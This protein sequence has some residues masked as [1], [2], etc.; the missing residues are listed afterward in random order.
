MPRELTYNARV[1]K[2]S[3]LVIALG[4]TA[5]ISCRSG[6]GHYVAAEVPEAELLKLVPAALSYAPQPVAEEQNRW[7]ALLTALEPRPSITAE[8]RIALDLV[9]SSPALGA[10]PKVARDLDSMI[11]KFEGSFA[12]ARKALSRPESSIGFLK[13]GELPMKTM[14]PIRQLVSLAAKKGTFEL[15]RGKV[16]AAIDDFELALNLGLTVAEAEAPFEYAVMAGSLISRAYREIRDAAW[17]PKMTASGVERLIRILPESESLH[18]SFKAS[19]KSDFYWFIRNEVMRLKGPGANSRADQDKSMSSR[20]YDSGWQQADDMAQTLLKDH[21]EPY[22]R[23][24]TVI[25]AAALY[26]EML[27]NIDRRWDQQ[28]MIG[29][30]LG[31]LVAEWPVLVLS[32]ADSSHPAVKA[33]VEKSRPGLL[34]AVNPYGRFAVWYFIQLSRQ[35]VL[36]PFRNRSDLEATRLTLHLR[37]FEMENGRLP[38]QLTELG[39]MSGL[40]KLPDDPFTGTPF[41][42]D[43]GRKRLWSAGQNGK[44]D[45]GRE[46]PTL[47]ATA[48]DYVYAL[49]RVMPSPTTLPPMPGAFSTPQTKG[50][51]PIA[52]APPMPQNR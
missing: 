30:T 38:A 11:A 39:G 19:V 14:G 44:D 40:A 28:T 29:E 33:E 13:G 18:R 7:T 48:R 16:E 35:S 5:G 25:R 8:E 37:K 9:T 21:P 2:G 6:P 36:I 10:D 24:D 26:Q 46:A 27:D 52:G 20:D 17:H 32:G 31:G 22:D 50:R 23:K 42:Y 1:R 51:A 47:S 45:G 43:P 12:Q 41:R 4:L 49:E 34:K 3:A 15:T